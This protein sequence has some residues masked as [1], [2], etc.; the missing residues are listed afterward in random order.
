MGATSSQEAGKQITPE[1]PTKE[2]PKDSKKDEPTA[3]KKD[4]PKEESKDVKKEEPKDSKKEEP[5]KEGGII[6][7]KFTELY[8]TGEIHTECSWKN[9]KLD[10]DYRVWRR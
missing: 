4:E 2:E 5:K 7:G 6:D 8:P 1:E 9:G 3:T 10:G